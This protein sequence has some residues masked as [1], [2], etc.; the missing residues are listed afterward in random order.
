MPHS[1]MDRFEQLYRPADKLI[2]NVSEDGQAETAPYPSPEPRAVPAEVQ[3]AASG[4]V[5]VHG[6]GG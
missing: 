1:D 4:G 3:G 5:R 2:G 6:G